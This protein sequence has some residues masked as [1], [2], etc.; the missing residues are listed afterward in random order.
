MSLRSWSGLAG[1][2]A[3]LLGAGE[4][5]ASPPWLELSWPDVP[6]CPTRADVEATTVRLTAGE[7][8]QPVTAEAQLLAEP[9]GYTLQ[10]RVSDAGGVQQ[11]TLQSPRCEALADATAVILAVAAAPLGVSERVVAVPPPPPD[12]LELDLTPRPTSTSA[13]APEPPPPP[14]PTRP[15][16]RPSLAIGFGAAA[17]IG[18]TERFTAGLSGTVSLLWQRARLDLRGGG[19][20]PGL[21]RAADLPG[22]G[23]DLQLAA[24]AVRGCPRLLRRAFALELCAGLELGALLAEGVGFPENSRSRGLWA[25]GLLAP[26]V[27]WRPLRWLSLRLEV[28]GLVAFTRRSYRASETA[29][30]LYTVRPVGVRLGGGIAL[31]FF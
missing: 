2:C 1:V 31:H 13:P 30:P 5:R 18:P 12:D 10:L 7:A 21:A 3:A 4:A 24:G 26:G 27:Q 8:P 15:S 16:R 29:D 11:R 6:G 9:A 14:P 23:V 22:I 20:F 25:A 28:E 19:W 17:G